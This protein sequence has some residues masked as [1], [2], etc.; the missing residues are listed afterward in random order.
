M[1]KTTPYSLYEILKETSAKAPEKIA[2]TYFGINLTYKALLDRIDE[3]AAA[4]RSHGIGQGDIVA[5]SLP[6]MPESIECFY[7]LHKID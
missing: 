7:A 5:V 1:S 4:F 3:I 6:T 2:I